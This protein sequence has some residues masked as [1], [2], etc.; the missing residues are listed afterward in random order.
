MATLN[1]RASYFKNSISKSSIEE[2]DHIK[3]HSL[4]GKVVRHIYS[5]LKQYTPFKVSIFIDNIE[6]SEDYILEFPVSFELFRRKFEYL[7]NLLIGRLNYFELIKSEVEG[8]YEYLDQNG[9]N[10]ILS[11]CEIRYEQRGKAI[12]TLK[13]FSLGLCPGFYKESD[14]KYQ[15]EALKILSKCNFNL[16][17][18]TALDYKRE[19]FLEYLDRLLKTRDLENFDEIKNFTT[20]IKVL[21]N[22]DNTLTD[23]ISY[24]DLFNMLEFN[25]KELFD[26]IRSANNNNL[27]N[28]NVL[29]FVSDIQNN[30]IRT[31]KPKGL[32]KK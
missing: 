24:S 8:D 12:D 32:K 29:K 2:I 3:A 22:G 30:S 6:L 1:V 13:Y 28:Q 19:K 25:P 17:S 21:L 23:R 14:F 15:K 31:V 4:F 18:R 10:K 20:P 27:N 11:D 7:R 5:F 16:E 26:K 9:I